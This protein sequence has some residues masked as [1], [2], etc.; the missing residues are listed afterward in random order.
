MVMEYLIR[1]ICKIQ[2]KVTNQFVSSALKCLFINRRGGKFH[3]VNEALRSPNLHLFVQFPAC[4]QSLYLDQKRTF[5]LCLKTKNRDYVLAHAVFKHQIISNSVLQIHYFNVQQLIGLMSRFSQLVF[6]L[7]FSDFRWAN[8]K[9][10]KGRL[11]CSEPRVRLRTRHP[12][13]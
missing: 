6:V 7:G 4:K 8:E 3:S 13:P 9:H 10:L 5:Q 12:P 11:N 1:P 2:H